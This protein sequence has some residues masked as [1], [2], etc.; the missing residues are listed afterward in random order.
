MSADRADPYEIG[1][2]KPP[3]AS[4]FRKGQSG[5]PKGRPRGRHKRP[6]YET[7]LGQLVTIREDGVERRVTAAEAFLL[8]ITKAGLEGDGAASRATMAAIEEARARRI[9]D[10][11]SYPT[12][13]VRVV[14]APGSVNPALELLRMGRKLD[15]YRETARMAL[16]PWIVEMALGRLGDQRLSLD[17]QCRVVKST[18]TPW[19]V[20]WPDWWEIRP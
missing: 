4:R 6:P 1:H 2:R 15:R 20:R 5:N 10:D 11:G 16:E 8:Q 12:Q 14:S 9:G 7:V 19:K 18:R 3:V 17:E 13:I